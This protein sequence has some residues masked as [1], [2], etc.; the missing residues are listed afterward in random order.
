MEISGRHPDSRFHGD[1]CPTLF[2]NGVFSTPMTGVSK[3]WLRLWWV[4]DGQT[5]S[6]LLTRADRYW[7][8]P[9]SR[10]PKTARGV[11]DQAWR[12]LARFRL[13]HR[14]SFRAPLHLNICTIHE[15]DESD[16][17]RLNHVRRSGSMSSTRCGARSVGS[18]A[19]ST[20]KRGARAID[21][22]VV[23]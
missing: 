5:G 10:N 14:F 16:G 2:L 8:T 12:P 19:C 23:R 4:N 20:Q 15:I 21:R 17:R 3:D 7:E 11:S 13:H 6:W 22:K 1:V 9:M 18:G